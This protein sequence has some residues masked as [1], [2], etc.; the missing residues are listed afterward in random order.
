MKNAGILAQQRWWGLVCLLGGSLAACG[1]SGGEAARAAAAPR[2]AATAGHA[3]G[4]ATLFAT[5][6][7]VNLDPGAAS[8]APAI[9]ASNQVAFTTLRGA[10]S[11]AGFF[12]GNIVRDV[13]AFGNVESYVAGLNNAGQTTGGAIIANAAATALRW[14]EA[15]GT[16]PLGTLGGLVARPSA[17]NA[18]GQVTGWVDNP[19]PPGFPRAFFWSEAAGPSDLGALGARGAIG[20]AI[21]D[22]GMVAGRSPAADRMDHAF[23]WTAAGGMVDL[24]TNGAI[25]SNARLI[26]NAGQVAG[27]LRIVR[28]SEMVFHGYVWDQGSGMV[29]IGTLGGDYAY[30][31]AM[32]QAGQVAGSSRVNC[33][34]CFHAIRWSAAGGMTDL[35]TLGG[36]YSDAFGINGNGDVVGWAESDDVS[37]RYLRAFAWSPAQGMVD[38][39]ARL[40][41]APQGLALTAAL[42]ISD[43]G[44]IVADSNAG[45]VLLTPGAGGTDAPVV[46]PMTP[47]GPV[48]AGTP[49]AFAATFSDRNS[50]DRHSAIWSWNDGC[51]PDSASKV[52]RPGTIRANHTFCAAGEYWVTFKVTDS[53]GRSTTVGRTLLVHD[54]LPA[55]PAVAG[56]GW[57]LSPRGA[58]KKDASHTGR[59]R[60]GFAAGGGKT[61][62]RFNVANMAFDSAACDT[63]SV[64]G[65]SARYQGSGTLNGAGNYRFTLQATAGAAS[66]GRLHMKIWHVDA[67]TQAEVVDYDNQ[68]A[69]GAAAIAGEG[70]AIAG[71]HIVMR[72]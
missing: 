46:G 10:L 9:N 1:N 28:P 8:G 42:A 12:N 56:S 64:A 43:S 31:S 25:D 35:G 21:N 61:M 27:S 41:N 66:Q 11:H 60:F 44:A 63:L 33:G 38:L 4:A 15:G 29:D 45:L 39:N 34:D 68:R 20:E 3:D 55:G 32:N 2:L 13:G 62:L 14:S 57:L 24:G 54:A 50:A 71:G 7:V 72:Q 16:L 5:Y 52:A 6:S 22:A 19:A 37:A 26:N 70:S 59:A 18:S 67:H 69:G 49:V 53:S 65:G 47:E 17:I 48:L 51:G 23:V 40:A 36:G 58:Y 30:I